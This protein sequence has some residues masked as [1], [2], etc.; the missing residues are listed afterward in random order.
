MRIENTGS[1]PNYNSV[2]T[3][4]ELKQHL[5]VTH[6]AEDTLI[7]ALRDAACHYV[8]GY[9]NT[10][11]TS[12][13]AKAYLSGF[14]A[15]AFPV[16]PVTAISSVDYQTSSDTSE[17]TELS[18]TNYYYHLDTQPAVIDWINAPS[19]YQYTRYPVVISFTYGYSSAP[20][21]IVHAVRLLAAHLY[22]N[23]QQVVDRN[24]VQIQMGVHAM[25]A[26]FRHIVQP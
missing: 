26:Q 21:P 18:E 22:E 25:L 12:R 2:L 19:F 13:T 8:E 20:D 17:L 1:A 5:R 23:R 14:R 9:C 16:G 10:Q 15:A 4:A 3:V 7:E 11:L 6:T 24:S